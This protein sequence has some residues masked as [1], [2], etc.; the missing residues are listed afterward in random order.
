MYFQPNVKPTFISEATEKLKEAGDSFGPATSSFLLIESLLK[1]MSSAVC[2][3]PT[4]ISLNMLLYV[5][6]PQSEKFNHFSRTG[7]C[8][9]P[10]H[11]DVFIRQA[12]RPAFVTSS[13]NILLTQTYS[14][15]GAT[16]YIVSSRAMTQLFNGVNFVFRSVEVY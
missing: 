13:F 6:R 9:G 3:Q 5:N 8:N 4:G 15:C 1:L 7:C 11:Y 12:V 10:A 16:C 14:L 2:H